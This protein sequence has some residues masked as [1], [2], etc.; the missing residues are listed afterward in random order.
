MSMNYLS[1]TK[2]KATFRLPSEKEWKKISGS[3][4]GNNLAWYGTYAYESSNEK[5]ILANVKFK[6]FAKEGSNYVADG[7]VYTCWVKNYKPNTLCVY[8]I[9]GNVAE[10]TL[11]GKIKGG[12]WDNFIVEYTVEKDQNFTIPDPRVGFRIMYEVMNNQYK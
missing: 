11:E 3:L 8:D 10:L 4:P 2:E 9:I 12:R 6:D 1:R 7:C 5:E